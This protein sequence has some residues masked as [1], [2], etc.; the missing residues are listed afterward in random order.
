MKIHKPSYMNNSTNIRALL[1]G[2]TFSASFKHNLSYVASLAGSQ[3][4]HPC[5]G[6]YYKNNNKARQSYSSLPP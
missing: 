4:W 6:F 1:D 5:W 2:D 3:N